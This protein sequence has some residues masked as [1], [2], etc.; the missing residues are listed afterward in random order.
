MSDDDD[1]LMMSLTDALTCVLAASV[2]LF[3][4]FVVFIKLVP[5]AASSSGSSSMSRMRSAV[6]ADLKTGDSTALVRI[7]SSDCSTIDGLMVGDAADDSWVVRSSQTGGSY[8]ARLARLREGLI[9]PIYVISSSMP[10]AAMS[11]H[12]EVGSEGWPQS[13]AFPLDPN[14]FVACSGGRVVLALIHN[15]D[16]Y[17]TAPTNA[18]CP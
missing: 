8:C 15:D 10:G 3:L 16:D 5:S 6:A 12:L 4:I 1:I 11:M 18:G 9:K 17:I 14:R 7:T 2:A 13:S